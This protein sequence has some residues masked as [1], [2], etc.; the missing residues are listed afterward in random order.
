MLPVEPSLPSSSIPTSSP[1]RSLDKILNTDDSIELAYYL[2]DHPPTP[3]DGRSF[4]MQI[5]HA[6][7][8]QCAKTYLH[9]YRPSLEDRD[10]DRMSVWHYAAL[11]KSAV[12]FTQELLRYGICDN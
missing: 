9:K 5:V 8:L 1:A 2:K 4:L 7:A 12:E 11:S 3:D 6:N 10:H